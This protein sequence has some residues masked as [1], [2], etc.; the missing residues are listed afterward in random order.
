MENSKKILIAEDDKFLAKML[1]RMLTESKYEVILASSGQEA[2][3]KA[4]S[5]DGLSLI[6]LDI[7]LPDLDGFDVLKKI[8][9]N[10]KLKAVPVIIMSNLGQPEDIKQ[11]KALGAIDHL[12]KS[13]FS[14]DEVAKKIK[15]IVG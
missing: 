9:E 10:S 11:G 2:I 8:K 3:D 6:I 7:M 1:S 5:E 15:K 12:I 13:D 4:G 14:L